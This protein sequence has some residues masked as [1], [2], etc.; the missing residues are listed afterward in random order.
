MWA[1]AG[2]GGIYELISAWHDGAVQ[3]TADELIEQ[4]SQ[5]GAVLVGH[6]LPA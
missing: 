6:F 2:I 3:A 1:V 4:A 5:L